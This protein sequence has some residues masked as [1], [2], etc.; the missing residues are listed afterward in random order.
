MPTFEAA[1]RDHNC[2]HGLLLIAKQLM[3]DYYHI[4]EESRRYYD[5]VAV[6]AMNA[7]ECALL[8]RLADS[9]FLVDRVRCPPVQL[10][11]YEV[12]LTVLRGTDGLEAAAPHLAYLEHYASEHLEHALA[13][14]S[15]R[16]TYDMSHSILRKKLISFLLSKARVYYVQNEPACTLRRPRWPTTCASP[17]PFSSSTSPSPS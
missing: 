1:S 14:E 6:A 13:Q 8:Q 15:Y 3:R 11:V 2:T 16:I 7:R 5:E 12:A 10:T 17:T 9:P 4:K